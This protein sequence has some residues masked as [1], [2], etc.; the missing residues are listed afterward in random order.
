MIIGKEKNLNMG[1]QNCNP[2]ITE[3]CNR[4]EL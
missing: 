3:N 2:T 4:N 1:V